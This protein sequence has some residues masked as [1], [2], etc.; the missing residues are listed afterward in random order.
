MVKL[1]ELQKIY[2]LDGLDE[3]CGWNESV[4]LEN[5][6]EILWKN[7]VKLKLCKVVQ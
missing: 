1:S 7:Q 6:K 5:I 2:Q 3:E 4:H